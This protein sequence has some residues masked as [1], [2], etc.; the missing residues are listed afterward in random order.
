MAE[1]RNDTAWQQ[2]FILDK[3]SAIEL[4]LARPDAEDNSVV[5]LISHDCDLLEPPD[6][7]PNCEVI[8][9]VK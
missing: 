1:Q 9:V 4:G 3:E 6:I 8:V 5:V 7:E 2:G